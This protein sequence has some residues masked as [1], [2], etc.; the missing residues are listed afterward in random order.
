[1]AAVGKPTVTKAKLC[2]NCA[3]LMEIAFDVKK[4]HNAH[5][6]DCGNCGKK[7]SIGTVCEITVK[8]GAE[9]E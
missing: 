2:D 7:T 1:M 6:F 4:L 3:L 9:K 5:D 8:K